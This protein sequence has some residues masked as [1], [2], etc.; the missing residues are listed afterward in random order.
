MRAC[1]FRSVALLVRV[2]RALWVKARISGLPLLV[3]GWPHRGAGA[4]VEATAEALPCFV[5]NLDAIVSSHGARGITGIV[6]PCWDCAKM[7]G[8]ANVGQVVLRSAR[9]TDLECKPRELYNSVVIAEGSDLS[10]GA[11]SHY[12]QVRKIRTNAAV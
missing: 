1:R 5:R 3:P 8:N 11:M 9:Y 7:K 2:Y 10:A 4:L 12:L 6:P